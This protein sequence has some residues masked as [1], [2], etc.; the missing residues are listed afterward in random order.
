MLPSVWVAVFL[1]MHG[2]VDVTVFYLV[3]TLKGVIVP[4]AIVAATTA[5]VAAPEWRATLFSLLAAQMCIALF[6]G[7]AIGGALSASAAAS[8]SVALYAVTIAVVA[9]F[10][11]GSCS[12]RES[13]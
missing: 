10:M 9:A 8:T 6:I 3:D 12:T 5:D 7:A 11:Q 1:H 13:A 4:P 2:F